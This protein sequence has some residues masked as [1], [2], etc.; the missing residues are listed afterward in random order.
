MST[1]AREIQKGW[2]V[3]SQ[4]LFL[5]ESVLCQRAAPKP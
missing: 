5:I 2:R 1:I 3:E 4:S